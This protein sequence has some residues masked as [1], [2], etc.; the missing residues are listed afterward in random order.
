MTADYR[1]G[2][3]AR[4]IL[5]QQ[6]PDGTWPGIFHSM[7]R[8][9]KAPLC[10]EQALR[11]LHILGFRAADE[12][13]RRSLCTMAACLRGERKIDTYW[14]RGLDWAMFEPLMLAAWIRRFDPEQPDAL[15]YGRRW[16]RVI[17][18]AFSHGSY[19]DATYLTA[20][21]DEF[22]RRAHH[23]RPLAFSPFYHAMLLPGLLQPDTESAL[24]QHLLNRPDGMYY[25]YPHA[26]LNPP[27]GFASRETASWLEAVALLAAYPHALEQLTFAS[28]WLQLSCR[29]DGTWD[30]GP[31]AN[32]RVH[33]PLADSWRSEAVRRADCTAH[34]RT[35]LKCI[36]PER[37]I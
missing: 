24:V 3:W 33:F 35:L 32:D 27:A 23:P 13:I 19:D 20:Y 29:P 34:I 28:V 22:R 21:E 15:A 11:R 4:A 14:E 10:T 1:Q 5:A 16:A 2:K 25:V 17:E 36:T 6:R 30:L 8:P 31:D 26:L 18:Q 7:A 37:K 9:G 12:P